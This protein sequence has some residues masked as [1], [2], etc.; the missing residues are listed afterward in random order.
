MVDLSIYCSAFRPK[1]EAP[2][3]CST[4]VKVKLPE[5]HAPPKIIINVDIRWHERFK[6]F[7]NEYTKVQFMFPKDIIRCI[8]CDNYIPTFRV[9]CE[10]SYRA[11]PLI[12]LPDT[13]HNILHIYT[14][15]ALD[16]ELALY[17]KLYSIIKMK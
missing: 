16:D 7:L 6:T 9:E 10:I 17:Y 5:L 8:M 2:R 3:R 14:L 1:N 15:R 12:S 4:V 13:D 11:E